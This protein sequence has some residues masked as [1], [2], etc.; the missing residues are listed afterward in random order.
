VRYFKLLSQHLI[1]GIE[2]NHENLQPVSEQIQTRY[3][4][5]TKQ[6]FHLFNSDY[7]YDTHRYFTSAQFY[8]MGAKLGLS[9]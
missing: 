2:H 3:L 4:P 1:G 7:P 8:C 6:V 5:I 9:L